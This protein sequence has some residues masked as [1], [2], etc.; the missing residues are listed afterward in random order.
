MRLECIFC[1]IKY[2]KVSNRK[3]PK[4][5]SANKLNKVSKKRF[6]P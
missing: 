4:Y 5:L 3:T 2:S 1:F 6:K